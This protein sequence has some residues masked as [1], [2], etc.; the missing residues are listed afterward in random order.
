MCVALH[1]M[2][3]LANIRRRA[4]STVVSIQ[5][6]PTVIRPPMSYQVAMPSLWNGQYQLRCD[7][8]YYRARDDTAL[9]TLSNEA[10]PCEMDNQLEAWWVRFTILRSRYKGWQQDV[11][12]FAHHHHHLLLALLVSLS[13]E[14]FEMCHTSRHPLL[15]CFTSTLPPSSAFHFH[16]FTFFT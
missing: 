13:S 9:D 6:M 11:L 4:I 8:E 15:I 10:M 1:R 12:M 5:L 7:I 16:F 14:I 3:D 2:G